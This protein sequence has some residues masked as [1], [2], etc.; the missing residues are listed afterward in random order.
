MQQTDFK[1]CNCPK[2]WETNLHGH[3]P[4]CVRATKCFFCGMSNQMCKRLRICR[5]GPFKANPLRILAEGNIRKG[6]H[7]NFLASIRILFF[8]IAPLN[9]QVA[10]SDKIDACISRLI[11]CRHQYEAM[12][13]LQN[14]SAADV[15]SAEKCLFRLKCAYFDMKKLLE[16]QQSAAGN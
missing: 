15:D 10:P 5:G 13:L 9:Q 14:V 6:M 8:Q 4:S 3:H 2:K 11:R 1:L 16:E 12:K 7:D